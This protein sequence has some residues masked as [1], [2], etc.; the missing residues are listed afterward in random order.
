VNPGLENGFESANGTIALPASVVETRGVSRLPI[1]LVADGRFRPTQEDIVAVTVAPRCLAQGSRLSPWY[2]TILPPAPVETIPRE[3]EAALGVVGL[4]AAIIVAVTP[5]AAPTVIFL[6]PQAGAVFE[7][8]ACREDRDSYPPFYEHPLQFSLGHAAA[9]G[10][11]G[12]IIGNTALV[13][14]ALLVHWISAEGYVGC[15]NADR[16]HAYTV[17]AVPLAAV[18]VAAI[19][20]PATV[21]HAVRVMVH[22]ASTGE[23]FVGVLVLLIWV[24]PVALVGLVVTR[25]FAAMWVPP[26]PT[27]SASDGVVPSA[28][29]T[30]VPASPVSDDG[31]ETANRSDAAVSSPPGNPAKKQEGDGLWS[32]FQ[33]P[34]AWR[35]KASLSDSPVD[36][37][38]HF[39]GL[40]RFGTLRGRFLFLVLCVLNM[41]VGIIVGSRPLEGGECGTQRIALLLVFAA[42]ALVSIVARPCRSLF[43]TV[44]LGGLA[45]FVTIA[46]AVPVVADSESVIAGVL[47]AFVMVACLLAALAGAAG[48]WVLQPSRKGLPPQ[49]VLALPLPRR[50]DTF[51]IDMHRAELEGDA[52]TRADVELAA[53]RPHT[54]VD[55]G[56]SAPREST[57]RVLVDKG[58]SPM[59]RRDFDDLLDSI[60]DDDDYNN[61]ESPGSPP[62][63]T[64]SDAAGPRDGR[65]GASN[66]LRTPPWPP[67]TSTPAQSTA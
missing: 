3:A 33:E 35:N 38:M 44:V 41:V 50:M 37:V 55:G 45:V 58:K 30:T 67:S 8:A 17:T 34:G 27:T 11:M 39:G 19:L 51:S 20:L 1:T 16:T 12:A 60:R 24:A 40:F 49:P 52:A 36:F 4:V 46:A 6:A 63:H 18:F 47:P 13:I 61:G 5:T 54:R 59:P 62:R 9:G 66:A 43:N 65:S 57:S 22:G 25:F 14:V 15:T 26:P 56:S 53:T 48:F 7:L 28:A 2:V 42:G 21:L 64:F 32:V 23:N 10:S 29:A 31:T